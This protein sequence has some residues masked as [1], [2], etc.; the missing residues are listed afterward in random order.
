MW[1]SSLS[2]AS[3]GA[4]VA[5]SHP[6]NWVGWL[7]SIT[8]FGLAYLAVGDEYPVRAFVTAPGSLSLA[9]WIG[10]ASSWLPLL[11]IGSI[12]L[13]FLLFPN[14]RAKSR[15][16]EVVARLVAILIVLAVVALLFHP[17]SIGGNN[18][19]FLHEGF[20]ITNPMGIGSLGGV[21][22]AVLT[23]SAVGLLAL[24]FASIGALYLR[25][26]QARGEE[27]Q[28][29]RWLAFMGLAAAAWFPL[30]PLALALGEDSIFG[31]LFWYGISIILGLGIPVASGTAILRYR[32]YDLDIVVKKTVV[33]GALLAFGGLVY[34]AV[35]VGIG[36]LVGGRGDSALTLAGAAIVAFAFQP[37]RTRALRFADRLVYGKRATPYE[38]LAEFSDRM[39]AG[40]SIEPCCH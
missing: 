20:R 38:V 37:L 14:G 29:L 24:L 31:P 5:R 10:Y 19:R 1:P 16:W 15:R 35:V 25:L 40:Y 12:V 26:R 39:T 17:G 23:V 30:L 6:R 2:F 21:L 13:V 22:G 28:Q 32:L 18:D 9:D 11:A 8:G 34:L 4:L 3:V 33:F 7:F 36:A 27:E